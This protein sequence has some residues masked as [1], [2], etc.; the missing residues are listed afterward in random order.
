MQIRKLPEAEFELMKIVWANPSPISTN[1]IIE[2]LDDATRWKPQTVLTLLTRLMERGFLRGERAGKERIYFP[3]VEREA[4]LAFES[5]KFI[6]RFHENSFVSLV[7]TLY[8]GNKLTEEDITQIRRWLDE[9]GEP[10]DRA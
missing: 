3:L 1:R 2:H 6:E 4:Y 9:R 8:E 5:S 10:H 7:N